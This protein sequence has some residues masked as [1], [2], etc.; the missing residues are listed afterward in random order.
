MVFVKASP[1]VRAKGVPV[2]SPGGVGPVDEP[3]CAPR[4]GSTKRAIVMPRIYPLDGNGGGRNEGDT[5]TGGNALQNSGERSGA[6]IGFAHGSAHAVT[7]VNGLVTQAVPPIKE[8]E[9]Y[10]R[11]TLVGRSLRPA[12]GWFV[13]SAKT[14]SSL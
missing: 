7:E 14:K 8:Q 4:N 2:P 12:S 10:F 11:K 3:H 9:R 6:G 5:H 1:M 13:G